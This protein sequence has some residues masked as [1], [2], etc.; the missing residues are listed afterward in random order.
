M[1]QKKRVFKIILTLVCCLCVFLGSG[2]ESR[3]EDGLLSGEFTHNGIEYVYSYVN[4]FQGLN[5]GGYVFNYTVDYPVYAVCYYNPSVSNKKTVIVFSYEPNILRWTDSGNSRSASFYNVNGVYAYYIGDFFTSIS[6]VATVSDIGYSNFETA[7]SAYMKSDE[8]NDLLTPPWE[9]DFNN[10]YHEDTDRWLNDL[11]A[12]V[13]DNTLYATWD[14]LAGIGLHVLEG[15]EN[16]FVQFHLQFIDDK[17]TTDISDD[18]YTDLYDFYTELELNEFS[19]DLSEFD[20]P[21]GYRLWC[22]W[23]EPY[24]YFND[25]I[26]STMFKGK[27]SYLFFDKDGMSDAPLIKDTGDIYNPLD[28]NLSNWNAITNFTGDYFYNMGNVMNNTFN[29]WD[30]TSM[31]ESNRYLGDSLDNYGNHENAIVNQVSNNLEG[32]EF[33]Y[34]LS[35]SDKVNAG[36]AFGSSLINKFFTVSGDFTILFVVGCVMVFIFVVVGIWR[37]SK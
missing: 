29:N 35:F 7:F 9:P 27:L 8:F 15:Y 30:S 24:W 22:M 10:Y 18:E 5:S 32:F 17:G 6:L 23:A 36:I 12:Q 25:D 3:A 16:M 14:G 31:D 33:D 1:K 28:P 13:E 37:F 11:R 34:Y 21:E 19:V 4:S 20:V 2:V 26:N